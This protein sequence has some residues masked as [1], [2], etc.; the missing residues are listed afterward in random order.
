[1]DCFK[2]LKNKKK[3]RNSKNNDHKCFQYV[4]TVAL[5]HQN[6]RSNPETITNSKNFIDQCDWKEINFPLNKKDWNKLKQ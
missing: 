4:V 6:I 2:W 1:M 5:N 3:T